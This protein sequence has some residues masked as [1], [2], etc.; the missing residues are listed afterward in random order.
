MKIYQ[1][2]EYGGEWEDS[3]DFIVGSF[4][5][6]ERAILEQKRL[7]KEEEI[8]A[9]CNSCPLYYCVDD[10][11]YDCENCDDIC[12][13]RAKQYCDRFEPIEEPVRCKNY[14]SKDYSCFF[15]EEVEVIE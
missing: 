4:V 13:E 8:I 11:N 9:K 5:S 14:F 15:I 2:H 6:R 10:C 1:I 7:E 3:Y 12:V